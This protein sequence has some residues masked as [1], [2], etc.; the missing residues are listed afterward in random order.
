MKT[1]DMKFT[2]EQLEK[3][4]G[5]KSPEELLALAKENGMEL[6]EEEAAK[7]FA[8][9]H[10][11]GELAEDELTQVS[12]GDGDIGTFTFY[13]PKPYIFPSVNGSPAPDAAD[14]PRH[15]EPLP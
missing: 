10:A 7:Y 13:I 4:K 11:E 12:G 2:N 6:T 8:E 1:N 9:L 15:E 3:A 5:A 14:I